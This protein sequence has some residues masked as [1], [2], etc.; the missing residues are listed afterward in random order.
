MT[1]MNCAKAVLYS[2]E[3][4]RAQNVQKIKQTITVWLSLNTLC[5]FCDETAKLER[6]PRP[7]A[8]KL[9]GKGKQ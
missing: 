1:D 8:A 2:S 6:T 5:G 9:E 3:S 4:I 7:P